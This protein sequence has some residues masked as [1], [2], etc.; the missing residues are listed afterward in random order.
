MGVYATRAKR[1]T[2]LPG[3]WGNDGK[4][5]VKRGVGLEHDRREY[6]PLGSDTRV[7]EITAYSEGNYFHVFEKS[8]RRLSPNT[9]RTS[10]SVYPRSTISTATFLSSVISRTPAIQGRY[11]RR[12]M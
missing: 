12:G 8:W 2:P 1:Y 10:D 4:G 11:P 7:Y 3:R 9:F 5:R 6:A